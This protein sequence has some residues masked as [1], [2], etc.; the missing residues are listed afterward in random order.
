MYIIY[1][2]YLGEVVGIWKII[3]IGILAFL[4]GDLLLSLMIS[5][6]GVKVIPVLRR[7]GYVNVEKIKLN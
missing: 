1:N 3:N 6:V 2:F 4:P 5:I 7:L